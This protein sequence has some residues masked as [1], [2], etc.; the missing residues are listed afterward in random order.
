MKLSGLLSSLLRN[1][2]LASNKVS[3]GEAGRIS[4]SRKTLAQPVLLGRID[5][6][7]GG[8]IFFLGKRFQVQSGTIEFG[9]PARTEP[10]LR[11][12]RDNRRTIQHH[13]KFVGPD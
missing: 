7:T 2:N 9:N 1:S 8:E 10:V 12:Y 3:M 4:T 6:L 13:A 5:S 11:L